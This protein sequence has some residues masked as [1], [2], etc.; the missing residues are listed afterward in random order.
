MGFEENDLEFGLKE[1]KAPVGQM[2]KY[3]AAEN[4]G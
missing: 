3:Q 4:M 2:D 1:H